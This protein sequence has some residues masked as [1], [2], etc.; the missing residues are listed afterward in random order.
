MSRRRRERSESQANAEAVARRD[1]VF[2]DEHAMSWQRRFDRPRHEPRSLAGYVAELREAASAEIPSRIHVHDVD[3]GGTP[4]FAPAFAAWLYGSPFTVD[5][6]GAY[7]TPFRACLAAMDRGEEASRRRAA[8]AGRVAHGAGPI[9]AAIA[10]GV[11]V[12]CARTV[13]LDALRV[14]WRRLNLAP[15]VLPR[16]EVAA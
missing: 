2:A 11:P 10:E 13:A 16:R 9:E 3:A 6:T 14:T 5:D 7:T 1:A 8:I 4:A 12:W 15:T